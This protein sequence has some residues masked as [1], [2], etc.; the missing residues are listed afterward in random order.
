VTRQPSSTGVPGVTPSPDP[1]FD[2][3]R[4]GVRVPVVFISQCIPPNTVLNDRDYE[5][6]SVVATVRKLFCPGSK[7]LTWREAQASTFDDVLTLTGDAIRTDVVKLPNPAVSQGIQI[8]ATAE[9]RTAT[10]LSV[11][12]AKAM[13]NSLDQANLK[14]A[15]D[16][17]T[18]TNAA[19]VSKYLRESQQNVMAGAAK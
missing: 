11:L 3:T 18:L 19:E 12:M 4:L 6:S 13:Q 14:S 17:S 5:H 16:V 10:D 1:P 2:F 15:G 7:P 9:Q 8:Q